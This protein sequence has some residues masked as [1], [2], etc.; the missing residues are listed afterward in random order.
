MKRLLLVALLSLMS[1]NFWAQDNISIVSI[2]SQSSD[3][4][5]LIEQSYE[6]QIV[7]IQ[8]D[9]IVEE[10]EVFRKLFA[11]VQYG[12]IVVPDEN[13]TDVDIIVEQIIDDK[14][15]SVTD[16]LTN[17]G[18]AMVYFTPEET[19]MYR[20]IIHSK[21]KTD[22]EFGFYSLIIFR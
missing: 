12:I 7:H 3:Y 17:E 11:D 21:H 22:N 20:L 4:I 13:L 18:V 14:W 15:T 2:I 19:G 9:V 10:K 6:K 8:Y 5:T 1:L 16:D